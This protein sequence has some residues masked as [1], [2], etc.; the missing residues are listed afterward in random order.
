[1]VTVCH[2]TSG[3]QRNDIRIFQKECK[4]LTRN[5]YKVF[6][7]VNDNLPN[8]I[9]DSVEIIS[10]NFSSATRKSRFTKGAKAIYKQALLI[11]AE[12]YHFH[13]P[14]L[15]LVGMKLKKKGKKIIFDSHENV[16]NQIMDK[17][18]LGPIILRKCISRVYA[19]CEAYCCRRFDGVISVADSIISRFANNNIKTELIK[20]YPQIEEF[21]FLLKKTAQNNEIKECRTI[22]YIGGLTYSRGITHLVKA[23][24]LAGAKLILA[25][26]I[27]S[28]YKE[29]LEGLIEYQCVEYKGVLSRVDIVTVLSESVIGMCT[30]LPVGQYGDVDVLATKVCEYMLASLPVINSYNEYIATLFSK[31]Q[32]GICVN[33]YDVSEISK[34]ILY[35]LDN[36]DIAKDMGENG[37]FAVIKSYNWETQEKKLVNFYNSLVCNTN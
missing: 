28:E 24:Y 1:M 29:E 13:D 16:P 17:K 23:T 21:E 19:I 30:L 25:G 11:D 3:H 2:L 22:C 34:A 7:I 4:S 31:E 12:L 35:L 32:C 5:G 36:R 37:R 20:N 15:L 9:K 18:W 33:P 26:P 14:E 6:L 27:T 8:E 10:T